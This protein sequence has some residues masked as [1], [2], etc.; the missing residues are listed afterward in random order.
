M[1]GIHINSSEKHRGTLS[2]ENLLAQ[3]NN[4]EL[5]G[6]NKSRNATP[7]GNAKYFLNKKITNPKDNTTAVYAFQYSQIHRLAGFDNCS[8]PSRAKFGEYDS[9]RERAQQTL[10]IRTL[11]YSQRSRKTSR[12]IIHRERTKVGLSYLDCRLVRIQELAMRTL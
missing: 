6:R 10:L 8:E 12:E 5:R 9:F 7:N 2:K 11:I 1:F 4:V 3:Q